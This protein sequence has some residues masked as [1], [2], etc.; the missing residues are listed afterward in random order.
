LPLGGVPGGEAGGGD[1]GRDADFAVALGGQGG[2]GGVGVVEGAGVALL[3]DQVGQ[4]E[5]EIVGGAAPDVAAVGRV[6]GLKEQ[7]RVGGGVA[8]GGCRVGAD[9][10]VVAEGAVLPEGFLGAAD[11][12][13]DVG[14][15]ALLVPGDD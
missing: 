6:Q 12:A 13:G 8:P 4:L 5:G 7:G 3:G 11:V 1:V 15:G 2:V 14:A 9:A 10:D